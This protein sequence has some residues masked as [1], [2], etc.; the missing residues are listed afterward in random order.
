MQHVV[1]IDQKAVILYLVVHETEVLEGTTLPILEERV[2]ARRNK[3]KTLTGKGHFQGFRFP[4]DW[5]CTR[6][7]NFPLELT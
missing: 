1:R 6:P 4:L 2:G 5:S 3:P 7:F